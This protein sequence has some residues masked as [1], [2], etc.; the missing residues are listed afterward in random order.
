M[1]QKKDSRISFIQIAILC[2]ILWL[3]GCHK[4]EQVSLIDGYWR[5]TNFTTGDAYDWQHLDDNGEKFL[6]GQI[7][8]VCDWLLYQEDKHPDNDGIFM[9]QIVDRELGL[10]TSLKDG[11]DL[12]H[13]QA[14]IPFKLKPLPGKPNTYRLYTPTLAKAGQIGSQKDNT[15]HTYVEATLEAGA[16]SSL[17]LSG[18]GVTFRLTGSED[19]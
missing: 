11:P 2:C 10:H 1:N 14:T 13:P 7:H 9:I 12:N 3:G 5:I 15:C 6:P 17:R 19:E 16:P 4:Q 8:N 18:N